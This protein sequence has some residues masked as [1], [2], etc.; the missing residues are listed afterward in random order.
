MFSK[1]YLGLALVACVAL[2]LANRTA[3]PITPALGDAG[4]AIEG[5]FTRDGEYPGDPF[6]D[7]RGVRTWASWSGSDD[8][9]GQIAIGPFPAPK[10]LRFGTGGY[11]H[12]TGNALY[13][14]RVDTGE[15]HL[16][17]TANVGERWHVVD[18]ELP[19]EWRGQSVRL[20]AVDRAKGYTG[21]LGVT[22]PVRGG[23]S[24]GIRALIDTLAAWAITGLLFGTIY[25]A[26]AGWL[27]DRT[28]TPADHDGDDDEKAAFPAHWIPLLAGAAVAACGYVVFW[29][30]LANPLLGK[31]ASWSLVGAATLAVLGRRPTPSAGARETVRAALLM[32]AVGGF[33]LGLVHLFPTEHDFFTLTA[34]RY[35][36]ARP[37]ENAFSHG[38]AEKLFSN[39]LFQLEGNVRASLGATP[40]QAGAQLL[41]T[42]AAKR[43]APDRRTF[44]AMAAFWLQLLWVPAGYGLLR[45]LGLSRA[46]AIGWVAVA[47]LCGV[48]ACN[49]VFTNAQFAAGALACGGFAFCALR[50][51]LAGPTPPGPALACG[52]LLALAWLTDARALLPLLALLPWGI[53]RALRGEGR[54]MLLVAAVFMV[55]TLPVMALRAGGSPPE[56]P[57]KPERTWREIWNDKTAA[58]CMPLVSDFS[59]LVD[60]SPATATERR[61]EERTHPLRALTWWPALAIVA[62]GLGGR[63]IFSAR[64]GALLALGGWTAATFTL[65]CLTASTIDKITTDAAPGALLLGLLVL[66][67]VVL[68]H[69]GRGWLAGLAVLQALTFASTWAIANSTIHG[70]P[71]GL[72]WLLA[73]AMVLGGFGLTAYRRGSDDDLVREQ[74]TAP[75]HW[76]TRLVA[77]WRD[78]QLNV[79]VLAALALLLFLRK[80]HALH[81]AQLWAEDGAIFLTQNDSDG[82]R[83][84]FMPYMGY[85]HLL[86]RLIAWTASLTFDPAWWPTFYNGVSF[87]I[88]L[89]VLGRIFSPRLDLPGKPWLVLAFFLGPNT[90]EVLFNITNLQWLTAFVLLQQALMRP[91]ATRVERAVDLVSA[92]LTGLTGPFVIVFAPLFAWRWWRDRRTDNLVLLLIVGACAATQAWFVVHTGGRF[93]YQAAPFQPVA[94]LNVLARRLFIWP[95]IGKSLALALPPRV[96]GALGGLFLA[97]LIAWALRPHPRR[98]LRVKII[99]AIG[100]IVLAGVYRTRPDTWAADNLY[101]ADRYFYIPRVLFAWLLIWEF[102]AVPR[103]VALIARTTCLVAVIVHLPDYP[104]PAPIDYHWPRQVEPIRRG[105]PAEIPILPEGWTFDYHGRP[106]GK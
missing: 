67:T 9:L 31:I 102:D 86:P 36:E 104:I 88:W 62:L 5:S 27:A 12:N 78:P 98:P 65:W 30:Y 42:P 92:V 34:N 93:D 23:R 49:T 47:A 63:R 43:L 82:L 2:H 17:E 90:G 80:P 94:A 39:Q 26:A 15:R 21:W 8:N 20:V 1:R 40:V 81:T 64:R 51:R 16:V 41:I 24:E 19:A 45:T 22:E 105:V 52:A 48:L 35:R 58:L 73:T 44:A 56:A 61:D 79:W 91:P 53:G 77:W 60:L 95:L 69:G 83:A 46:R 6:A 87:A 11:P 29:V 76:Q 89:A 84:W 72:P 33:H 4:V 100:F 7:A 68:E 10:I 85:L 3:P 37:H 38:V 50:P 103:V 57:A 97:S 106:A 14:E 59:T 25:F 71:T 96:V 70:P 101:Y 66:F 74:P 28:R 75:S 99:A 32:L 13:V 55:A 54:S 18:V